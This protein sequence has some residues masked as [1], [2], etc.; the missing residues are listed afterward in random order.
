MRPIKW[1]GEPDHDRGTRPEVAY[2]RAT[3]AEVAGVFAYLASDEA[4][5]ISGAIL[6]VDGAISA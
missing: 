6:S 4:A 2:R 1:I 3:P 5:Y